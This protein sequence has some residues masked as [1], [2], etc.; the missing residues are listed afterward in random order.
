[1]RPP[2]RAAHVAALATAVLFLGACQGED[3]AA[4]TAASPAAPA[5]PE[6]AKVGGASSPCALPVTFGVAEDWKAKAVE[7]DEG[8]EVFEAFAK[9]GPMTMVCEIDAKPA[10]LIGFLRVWTGKGGDARENLTAFIGKR[11][12]K[13]VFTEAQIGG[14]P[15][16]EVVYEQKSQLDDE[17]EPERAFVVDTGQGLV[18]VSL[19]S[20]DSSEYEDMLP[21]YD[22]AKSSLTVNG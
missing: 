2:A 18:A 17:I 15:G 13:P 6:S 10:G 19:D 16:L 21:A 20:F 22:L 4:P 11:A 5:V 8:D 7:Q 9:R 3:T 1:M 14:R 12:L